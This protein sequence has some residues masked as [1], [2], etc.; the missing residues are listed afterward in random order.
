MKM[1]NALALLAVAATLVATG[2]AAS[3][4]NAA[5]GRLTITRTASGLYNVTVC[6]NVSNAYPGGAYTEI[7]L[8][9]SDTFSDDFLFGPWVTTAIDYGAYPCPEG[10]S[11]NI[12]ASFLVSG[13]TLNEDWGEDEV[14]AGVRARNN[15][16]G[17]VQTF[18]TNTISRSF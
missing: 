2:L 10:G 12:Y 7:R 11:G 18:S 4:A 1:R 15:R 5:G 13:S 3:P 14:Y 8:W 9:G 16:N 17:S 6:G